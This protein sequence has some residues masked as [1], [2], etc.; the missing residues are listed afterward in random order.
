MNKFTKSLSTVAK[1]AENSFREYPS[2]MISALLLALLTII[3]IHMDWPAQEDW[4]FFLTCAQY[5]LALGSIL[6]LTLATYSKALINNKKSFYIANILT[7]LVVGIVFLLLYYLG[8]INGEGSGNLPLQLTSI[9]QARVFAG[10]LISL[11]LFLIIVG[12]QK[13]KSDFSKAFFMTHK[14]YFIALIYGIVIYL[15]AG[16]IAGA[17][18]ALLYKDLSFNIYMYIGTIAGF[19]AFAIFIGYFPDFRKDVDDERRE[20]AQKQ[21]RFI[22]ALFD[23]IMVPL[24][25]AL[26]LVLLLWAGK[27]VITGFNVPFFRLSAIATGF[28]LI[29][30]WLHIMVTHSSR[31]TAKIYRLIYPIAALLILIFEAIALI[32]QVKDWGIKTAEYSFAL[33][34][35]L[36]VTAS[37]L[38]LIKK[39]KSHIAIAF[40]IIGL[41]IFTVIPV[42]GYHALPVKSQIVRLENIL[43]SNEMLDGEK[44][45]PS[46]LDTDEKIKEQITDAVDFLIKREK[47]NLPEWL[48][49]SLRESWKFKET[50]GFE[51][52][53]P[54][55]DYNNFPSDYAGIYLTLPQGAYDI[56]NYSWAIS[57]SESY[58]NIPVFLE[59]EKGS[60]EF[61]WNVREN[62][63]PVLKVELE[64]ETIV[65]ESF[66]EY[67]NRIQEK[68]P[69]GKGD[70]N[71]I[72]LEDMSYLIEN[73]DLELLVIINDISI[74]LDNRTGSI[75]YWVNPWMIYMNEKI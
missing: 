52:T 40:V 21:P 5:S 32:N 58:N 71:S 59:G 7:L 20:I 38:L 67:L 54:S 8:A 65:E 44:I 11:F 9:A 13:E 10:I 37:V 17:V 49:P 51:Q 4:N 18:Q 70:P 1:G 43:V 56:K 3:R 73:G 15:G 68:Y 50:F 69:P 22:E 2:A 35:I 29:G 57:L 26:T 72:P 27:T 33:L 24:M 61:F 28:T 14:A 30:L 36:L 64:G 53:W 60:Y 42:T 6:G 74:N 31:E 23:Y 41:T 48:S 39:E 47:T 63:I 25:L 16:G 75:G 19:L 12:S 46:K 62:N 45:T 66:E 34:L 55:F